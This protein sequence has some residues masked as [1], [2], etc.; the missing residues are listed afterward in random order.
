MVFFAD[1][2]HKVAKFLAHLLFAHLTGQIFKAHE[3]GK[4]IGV[5]LQP[6]VV[7]LFGI[8]F[9]V[10]VQEPFREGFLEIDGLL[11]IFIQTCKDFALD[12]VADIGPFQPNLYVIVFKLSKVISDS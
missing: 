7:N 11:L 3:E 12:S 2:L 1:D 10:S 6:N 4:L 8:A 9:L 5:T